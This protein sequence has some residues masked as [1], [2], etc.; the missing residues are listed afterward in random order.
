MKD[1]IDS[2]KSKTSLFFDE[3]E[4]AQKGNKTAA[5]RSRIISLELRQLLKDYRALSTSQGKEN[6]GNEK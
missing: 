6:D 5:K 1:V 3:A 4:K 2:I